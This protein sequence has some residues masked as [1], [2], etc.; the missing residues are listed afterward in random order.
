MPDGTAAEARVPICG[1]VD[2]LRRECDRC[3]GWLQSELGIT[4]LALRARAAERDGFQREYHEAMDIL[5]AWGNIDSADA[6]A[7][8]IAVEQERDRLA[9]RVAGL[10]DLYVFHPEC[11]ACDDLRRGEEYALCDAHNRERGRLYES[12]REPIKAALE[13]QALQAGARGEE[14]P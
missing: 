10:A 2:L 5:T 4:R 3:W 9:E 11:D 8:A 1:H 12:V 13:R 14:T 6:V 7:R